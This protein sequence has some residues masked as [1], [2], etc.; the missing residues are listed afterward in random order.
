MAKQIMKYC[1]EDQSE[2]LD[3]LFSFDSD[4][5]TLEEAGKVIDEVVK[6]ILD[7]LGESHPDCAFL[8]EDVRTYAALEAAGIQSV[9]IDKYEC[10]FY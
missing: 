8:E 9:M 5:M 10:P 2:D 3:Y 4:V 6:Q 1:F 7:E